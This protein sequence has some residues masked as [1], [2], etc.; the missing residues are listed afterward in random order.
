MLSKPRFLLKSLLVITAAIT[1][2]MTHT[3][4]A[5]QPTYSND[6]YPGWLRYTNE[7]RAQ[8]GMTPLV[9]NG[10]L[11][12][13]GRLHS[14]YLVKEDE[15][16]HAENPASPL[17]SEAGVKAAINGNIYIDTWW[18]VS[19]KQA[20][21]FWISAP[22]HAIPMFNPHLQQVG[23]GDYYEREGE[24]HYGATMDVR[25]GKSDITEGT[26]FPITFPGDGG[27]TWVT[28]H[29]LK[30]YPSPIITC[31]GYE[32]PVGAPV[33]AQL[34]DGSNRPL[35]TAYDLS[36]E[37]EPLQVC[38]FNELTYGHPKPHAQ[39]KGL[40]ILDIQDAVVLMPRHELELGQYSAS[41]SY[42]FLDANDEAI[43][44]EMTHTWTFDVVEDP[45]D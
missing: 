33:M 24:F 31:G 42:I 29:F 15:P 10:I 18:L 25:S 41:I 37:G 32:L 19:S 6:S 2:F 34:G 1:L 36:Y 16:D 40:K 26:V 22:F 45:Y 13:G 35:I 12:M 23:Y 9:E 30:E 4:W 3:T 43:S 11:S 20:I 5:E 38:M 14:I 44:E 8:S 28:S 39:A 27:E 21:D 7:F 17:Y